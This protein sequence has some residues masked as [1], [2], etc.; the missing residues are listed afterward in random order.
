MENATCAILH[1]VSTSSSVPPL[2]V[3]SLLRYVKVDTLIN[4]SLTGK[5]FFYRLNE[6]CSQKEPEM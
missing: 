5:E 1:L 6:K 4:D 3:T 2:V